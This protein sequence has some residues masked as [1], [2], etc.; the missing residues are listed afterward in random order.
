MKARR[1]G[2]E[3]SSGEGERRGEERSRE[4]RRGGG[5]NKERKRGQERLSEGEQNK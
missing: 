3:E 5:E 4:S 1:R 2:G